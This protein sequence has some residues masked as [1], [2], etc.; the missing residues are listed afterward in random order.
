[1]QTVA[2]GDRTGEDLLRME[3]E[4]KQRN[5]ERERLRVQIMNQA[6]DRMKE[7]MT[8]FPG[9]NPKVCSL[10][11]FADNIRSFYRHS[12]R[13]RDLNDLLLSYI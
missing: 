12:D 9:P 1:M 3:Q 8:E 13:Y 6:F 10:N 5:N 2:T 4:R 11:S 7:V